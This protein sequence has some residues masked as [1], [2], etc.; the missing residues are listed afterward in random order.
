MNK[1]LR[2]QI[3]QA[4]KSRDDAAENLCFYRGT[5]F[6]RDKMAQFREAE[7]ELRDLEAELKTSPKGPFWI[8]FC[9]FLWGLPEMITLAVIFLFHTHVFVVFFLLMILVGRIVTRIVNAER[10]NP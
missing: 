1:D 6:Y 10:H 8:W 4:R 9:G 2:T 7:Q 5:S 3:A